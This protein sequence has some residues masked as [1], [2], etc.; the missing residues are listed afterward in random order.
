MKYYTFYQI[1]LGALSSVLYGAAMGILYSL[2]GLALS[3][4]RSL[5][6]LPLRLS[7]LNIGCPWRSCIKIFASD[8]RRA[9]GAV[10][11]ICDFIYVLVFGIGMLILQ[12]AYC[13]GSF[14]IYTVLLWLISAERAVEKESRSRWSP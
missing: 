9:D 11:H 6:I 3:V 7:R 12:Y 1:L 13:D 4:I 10:G 14:R 2:L 5:I 8:K